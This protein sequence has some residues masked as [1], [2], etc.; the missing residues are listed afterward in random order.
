MTAPESWN[1]DGPQGPC[2]LDYREEPGRR[3]RGVLL[4]VGQLRLALRV[5]HYS[6]NTEKAYV[7]WLRRFAAY[8]QRRHPL[9]VPRAVA[10][11]FLAGL[12]SDRAGPSTQN[13]AASALAFLWKE[14]LGRSPDGVALFSRGRLPRRAPAVLSPQEVRAVLDALH[15]PVR[16]VAALLYG[17]GLRLS[18]CCR[19][20]VRDLDFAGRQLTVREGKG[21]KDRLGLLPVSLMDELRAHLAALR[22]EYDADLA[23]GIPTTGQTAG[24][25]S[26]AQDGAS[27]DPDSWQAQW[28]FPGRRLR[29]DRATGAL[30]R[31]HL[32][33]NVVQ[34]AFAAAVRAAGLTKPATCHVLRHSF[35]TQLVE[36]GYDIRTIQELLG[37][38]DVATTLIYARRPSTLARGGPV[39]SPL[40]AG[41]T[42]RDTSIKPRQLREGLPE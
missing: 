25:D 21:G 31:S 36:Q 7:A 28:L 33:P 41:S 17:A 38:S 39:T 24:S 16:L 13:Q 26:N 5:R 19:L 1:W 9:D 3:V 11:R 2:E 27:A 18:E 40:D 15:G 29:I 23:S 37:H 20:R 4:V 22:V 12:S 10:A 14:V 42:R 30:R 35:A 34:R 8:C 6:R 32:H